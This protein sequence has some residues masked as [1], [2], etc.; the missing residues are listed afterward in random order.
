MKLD[1]LAFA[2]HPDDVELA[3]S[4]TVIKHVNAG[5]KVGVVDLTRG[6]LGTRG[7]PDIREE[8]ANRA[9]KIMGLSIRDNLGFRDIFFT[10]DEAHQ[11]EVVKKIRQYQPDIVL[12]NA[13]YDRHPDHPRASQL[14]SQVCFMAGLSKMET[15]A[16]GKIQKEWKPT[17]IY[18]YVQSSYVKPDFVVDISESWD[19]KMESI[20]AYSSQ[21][22]NPDS[23]EPETFISSSQFLDLINARSLDLGKTI[24]A[25]HGEGFT[26]ERVPGIK[27]LFDLI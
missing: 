26:V 15:I 3:C 4:G 1:I 10:N 20:K 5:R 6:E 14:I 27:D 22:H 21:F 23:N 12:A 8:E 13:V 7:N 18:H 19:R 25:S 16:G 24:G 2:A 9:A 17:V 11:L